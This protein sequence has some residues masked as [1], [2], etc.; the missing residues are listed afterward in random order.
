[1]SAFAGDVSAVSVNLVQEGIMTGSARKILMGLRTRAP[2][3]L[4]EY[5]ARQRW[6]GGKARSIRDVSVRDLVPVVPKRL[7]ITLA[8]VHYTQGSKETYVLP[9]AGEDSGAEL[10]L[11]D[12]LQ[13]RA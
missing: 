3:V 11:Q 9:M 4:P 13:D 7:L 10:S 2:I 8:D 6:F 5:L 12:A 1:V